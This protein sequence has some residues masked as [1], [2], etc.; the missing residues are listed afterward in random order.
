VFD[1]TLF[2]MFFQDGPAVMQSAWFTLSALT[3]IV[4]IFSLRTKLSFLRSSRPAPVLIFLAVIAGVIALVFPSSSV[5]H[6]IFGFTE[7]PMRFLPATLILTLAYFAATE[8]AKGWW[9]L[10]EAKQLKRALV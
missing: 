1:L 5:G 9:R 3:E 10:R 2:A 8:L 4:L 7:D 6:E